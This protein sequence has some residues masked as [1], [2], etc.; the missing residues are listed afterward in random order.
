M[1]TK[2]IANKHCNV[3]T[4]KNMNHNARNKNTEDENKNVGHE[5]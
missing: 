5:P 2:I 1:N 3:L 4:T